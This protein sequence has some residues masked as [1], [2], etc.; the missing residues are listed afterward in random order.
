ML[1]YIV[2][3]LRMIGGTVEQCCFLKSARGQQTDLTY[4]HLLNMSSFKFINSNELFSISIL[5]Y[6]VIKDTVVYKSH[7]KPFY[8]ISFR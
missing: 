5:F 7:N 4:E 1:A 6:H 2:C 3:V 8:P